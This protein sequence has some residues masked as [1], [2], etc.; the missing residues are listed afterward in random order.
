MATFSGLFDFPDLSDGQSELSSSPDSSD[1]EYSDKYSEDKEDIQ[2]N[3]PSDSEDKDDNLTTLALM[4]P[5]CPILVST[6]IIVSTTTHKEHSTSTRIKAIYMLKDKKSL[7]Q[8]KEATGVSKTA[9]Y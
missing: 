2:Y 6:A 1:D 7:A 8:I 3:L 9:V 5:I 4:L